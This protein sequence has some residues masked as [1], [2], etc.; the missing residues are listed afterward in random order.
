MRLNCFA[1]PLLCDYCA[2]FAVASLLGVAK[3]VSVSV[4]VCVC[5]FVG[6][7]YFGAQDSRART[8]ISG[9][10]LSSA[11]VGLRKTTA[12]T[13]RK[14]RKLA[15]PGQ[16]KGRASSASVSFSLSLVLSRAL[17]G[18]R[19]G[20]GERADQSERERELPSAEIISLASARLSG[21]TFAVAV[22]ATQALQQISI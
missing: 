6:R 8:H 7:E 3:L 11:A 4:C 16:P 19:E 5:L 2:S 14:Q 17:F 9:K 21:R 10:P 13:R 20:K 1:F 12:A 18:K 15:R 22:R